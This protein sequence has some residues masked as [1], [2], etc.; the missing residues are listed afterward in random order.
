VD[1][2]VPDF[3]TRGE[4][5]VFLSKWLERIVFSTSAGT[6]MFTLLSLESL[7]TVKGTDSTNLWYSYRCDCSSTRS[8]FGSR[9][10]SRR[11]CSQGLVIDER[12]K[13]RSVHYLFSGGSYSIFGSLLLL[14][15]S[16][17]LSLSH[18]LETYPTSTELC[19]PEHPVLLATREPRD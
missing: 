17:Y 15:R 7:K 2:L 3:L 19:F 9:Q 6:G 16:C 13:R 14:C 4:F 12:K 10:G 8:S 11:S 18:S 1:D 5:G